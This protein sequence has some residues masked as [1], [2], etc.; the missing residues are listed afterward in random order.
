M[1]YKHIQGKRNQKSL[2]GTPKKKIENPCPVIMINQQ[3]IFLQMR[4]Y[5]NFTNLRRICEFH[6]PYY[7][8]KIESSRSCLNVF[9]L[10]S[11]LNTFF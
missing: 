8:P 9:N 11:E 10:N 3:R 4:Y 5:S 1:A 2:R 7:F 6:P